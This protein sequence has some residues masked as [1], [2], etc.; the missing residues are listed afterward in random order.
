ML[1]VHVFVSVLWVC[2]LWLF[3]HSDCTALESRELIDWQLGCSQI[4]CLAYTIFPSDSIHY[5]SIAI[6]TMITFIS[7]YP[8]TVVF[9]C[10][11][12]TWH[13]SLICSA[14]KQRG[15]ALGKRSSHVGS[16]FESTSTSAHVMETLEPLSILT[17]MMSSDNIWD[18]WQACLHFNSPTGCFPSIMEKC[19]DIWL[20]LLCC[21][22]NFINT[23]EH[24]IW[25]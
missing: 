13:K 14:V 24:V 6:R 25:Y 10:L 9:M 21:Y 5:S 3:V 2:S 12:Q 16:T 22:R 11:L 18:L 7:C 4:T 19:V 23:L 15:E 1:H 17:L 20:S 8:L